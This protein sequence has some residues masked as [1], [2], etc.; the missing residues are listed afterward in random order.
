MTSVHIP[1]YKL[2]QISKSILY[3]FFV[4]SVAEAAIG[5]LYLD[6][7]ERGR[8]ILREKKEAQR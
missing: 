1:A 4:A 5:L 3:P 8:L 7:A 2:P 6:V